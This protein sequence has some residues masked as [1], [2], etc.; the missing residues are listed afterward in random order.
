MAPKVDAGDGA[1][2]KN[3]GHIVSVFTLR[4]HT[5]STVNL[6]NS[7]PFLQHMIHHR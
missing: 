4:P 6:L 3:S 5:Y 7:Q 2:N 1:K